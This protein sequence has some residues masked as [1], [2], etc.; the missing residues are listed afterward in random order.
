VGSTTM[1]ILLP[2]LGVVVGA[3]LQYWLG[4]KKSLRDQLLQTRAKAYAD[5][6]SS[7]SQKGRYPE[8]EVDERRRI[9]SQIDDA[10]YRICVYGSDTVISALAEF[11]SS[12]P[13]TEQVDPR[14]RF[15]ALCQVMRVDSRSRGETDLATL[16]LAM[17]G[18]SG[19]SLLLG[20]KPNPPLQ[21][22]SGAGAP[23]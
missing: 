5:Y 3:L 16:H 21:P 15:L 13:E 2:L 20:P 12:S 23:S 19:D 4:Q 7:V 9:L 14:N 8:S 6:L 10:K 1:S 11:E 18:F 22:P 17:Y